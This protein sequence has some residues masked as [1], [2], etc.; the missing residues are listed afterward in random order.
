[1]SIYRKQEDYE[2]T[3]EEFCKNYDSSYYFN[4]ESGRRYRKG[5]NKYTDLNAE[6]WRELFNL[7]QE[8]EEF[9]EA[10]KNFDW[11]RDIDIP[12]DGVVKGLSNA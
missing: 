11:R 5:V 12:E 2:K 4:K 1:M 3:F 6:E 8:K 10:A 9:E 7:D